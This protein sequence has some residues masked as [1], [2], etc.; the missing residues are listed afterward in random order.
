MRRILL[1][2]A[3][4][5]LV[6]GCAGAQ[7]GAPELPAGPA[8]EYENAFPAQAGFD[9]P[10]F[11]AFHRSDAGS[12]YVVTQPGRV[13]VVPRDGSKADRRVFLDLS[14]RVYLENWEEGL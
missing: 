5:F 13:L 7:E 11:V 4:S 3:C 10:L 8:V 6:H 2:A 9:R 1:L 12:A 14:G